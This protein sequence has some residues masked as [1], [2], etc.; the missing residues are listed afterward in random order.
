MSKKVKK[1]VSNF[2]LGHKI[3]KG[4]GLPDPAGDAIYGEYRTLSPAEKAAAAAEKDAAAIGGSMPS[5]IPTIQ[6]NATI[7][8]RED[9]KRRQAAAAGLSANM[10]TGSGGLKA[11]ANTGMK[12]LLG[13]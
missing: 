1:L 4:M 5:G 2:D 11:Q 7:A 12:S 13:S 10:L 8:A 3:V 9:Q 6:D